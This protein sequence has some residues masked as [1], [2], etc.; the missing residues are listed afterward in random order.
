MLNVKLLNNQLK[1]KK[2]E[3]YGLQK[4][5]DLRLNKKDLHLLKLK[6]QKGLQQLKLQGK[7]DSLKPKRKQKLPKHLNYTVKQPLWIWFLICYQYMLKKL[8]SH[9]EILI[10]SLLSMLAE[11]MRPAELEKCQGM[12]LT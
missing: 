9:L 3:N 1:L 10:K 5:I 8:P 11:M 12:R 2:Q 7:K 6:R 4:H